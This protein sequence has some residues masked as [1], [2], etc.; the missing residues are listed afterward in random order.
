MLPA[1]SAFG[2]PAGLFFLW[3]RQMSEEPSSI[4][5]FV[6]FDGQNL[7]HSAKEAFGYTY[8]N[9][10]PKLLAEYICYSRGWTISGIYFYTGIPSADVNPVWNHFWIA[11]TAVMG[12]RGIKTFVR[13]LRYRNQVVSFRDGSSTTTLVGQEKGVDVRIALDVV[14]FALDAKYDVGLIFSQDQDLTEAVEDVKKIAMIQDRW[15]RLACAYPVSPTAHNNRG[16]NGTDWI[17]LDRAAY[18]L[19][20]D[21]IDYRLK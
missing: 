11:K 2:P 21:T 4:R 15:I 5:T 9:Y 7:F 16:I 1:G 10:S 13:T 17:K 12:T 18:D 3:I 14:R 6:F 8:P 20:L 19:C